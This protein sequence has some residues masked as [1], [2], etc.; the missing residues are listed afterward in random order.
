MQK[1]LNWNK[2]TSVESTRSRMT[3]FNTIGQAYKRLGKLDS[4]LTNY[5]RSMQ[6]SDKLG[7]SV[8]RGINVV[9]IAE[10]IFLRKDY[11][12]ARRLIENEYKV[13][14]SVEPYVSAYGLQLLARINLAQGDKYRALQQ[15]NEAKQLLNSV[16]YSL[17]Q[18]MDYL[19]YAYYA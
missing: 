5:E 8:W 14:Y 6:L 7:D 1:A 2:D 10:V 12:T 16:N 4:A 18:K 3:N 19:Q 11:N 9:F 13:K 15:V 17:Y